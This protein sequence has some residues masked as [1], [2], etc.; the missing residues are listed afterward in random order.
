MWFDAGFNF[1]DVLSDEDRREHRNGDF[2]VRHQNSAGK[3]LNEFVFSEV[4]IVSIL[5]GPAP[6]MLVDF[7]SPL[8]NS[9]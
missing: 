6:L 7:E 8:C 3:R 2:I 1:V 5:S 9:F 4:P